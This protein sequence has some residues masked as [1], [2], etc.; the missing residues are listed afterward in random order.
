MSLRPL[1]QELY[2]LE[3]KVEH[4][5]RELEQAPPP[6]KDKIDLDLLRATAERDRMRAILRAKK[7]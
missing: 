7:G 2:A 1:A 6:R 4:L 5:R 3:R